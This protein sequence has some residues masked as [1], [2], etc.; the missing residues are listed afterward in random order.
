MTTKAK[1]APKTASVEIPRLSVKAIAIL[2]AL[3]TSDRPLTRDAII[4]VVNVDGSIVRLDG[5]STTSYIGSPQIDP[6]SGVAKH[7]HWDRVASD[8][9]NK[10]WSWV[11][12]LG[13][14]LVAHT[15]VN[16]A[17]GRRVDAFSLTADGVKMVKAIDQ[18]DKAS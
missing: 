7:A 11:S 18:R 16:N 1:T 8:P 12:L 4:G 5:P 2:R 10:S 15:K 3:A 17:K 13:L 9:D 14:G 6:T